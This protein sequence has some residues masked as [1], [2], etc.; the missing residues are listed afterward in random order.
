MTIQKFPAQVMDNRMKII[1]VN[2]TLNLTYNLEV[3]QLIY[4]S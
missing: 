2:F 1:L 4:N 3:V